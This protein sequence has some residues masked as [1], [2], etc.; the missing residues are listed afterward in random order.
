MGLDMNLTKKTYIGWKFEHRKVKW[1]VEIEVQ[2]VLKIF[3]VNNIDYIEEQQAYR[4][5][6]NQIHKW[7]VDHV[8][9]GEDDCGNHYVS[10]EQLE[11]LVETCKQVIENLKWQQLVEKE[12]DDPRRKGGK[13]KVMVYEDTKLAMKLLPPQEWFFFGGTYLNEYYLKDL[14]NTVEQLKDLDKMCDYY[15]QSSR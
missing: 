11:E 10:V 9:D 14:E 13:E 5:K 3:D 7:F 2:W 15:Y 4:R 6:A 8:Q 1:I 12:F